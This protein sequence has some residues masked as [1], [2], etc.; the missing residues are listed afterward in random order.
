[1]TDFNS[2]ACLSTHINDA[3]SLPSL[4]TTWNDA[5]MR[6]KSRQYL[7]AGHKQDIDDFL[8]PFQDFWATRWGALWLTSP[9]PRRYGKAN[10]Q[11][12]TLQ[13]RVSRGPLLH[14]RERAQLP[15]A[16][17][18][19]RIPTLSSAAVLRALHEWS[20]DDPEAVCW[21]VGHPA[22]A[23]EWAQ[24]LSSVP[25][26]PGLPSQSSGSQWCHVI[27]RCLHRD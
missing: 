27:A 25:L 24:W 1:M 7:T 20:L 17:A 6:R 2:Q 14:R 19:S 16:R 3:C 5:E 4:N 10:T 23:F 13:P 21:L 8:F 22:A 12:Q 15:S 26:P 9:L 11:D 18:A